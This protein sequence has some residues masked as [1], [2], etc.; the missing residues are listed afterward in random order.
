VV[1]AGSSPC[2]LDAA[3]YR[4][5]IEL[6]AGAHTRIDLVRFGYDDVPVTACAWSAVK[7]TFR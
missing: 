6:L 2:C 4:L 1:A 3:V 5:R 7:A